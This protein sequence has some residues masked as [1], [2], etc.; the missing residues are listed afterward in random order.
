MTG[1]SSIPP[2]DKPQPGSWELSLLGGSS[3]GLS[4]GKPGLKRSDFRHRGSRGLQR[5]LFVLPRA[6]LLLQLGQLLLSSG[7]HLLQ[8]FHLLGL[9]RVGR[10]GWSGGGGLLLESWKHRVR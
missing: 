3:G 5:N 1:T 7:V 2:S 9:A 6:L 8:F 10:D 4:L